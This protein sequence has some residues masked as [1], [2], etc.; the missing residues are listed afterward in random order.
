M[1][2]E[3][4]YYSNGAKF[5]VLDVSVCSLKSALIGSFSSIFRLLLSNYISFF[6]LYF[7]WPYFLFFVLT[8][9][10]TDY[11]AHTFITIF[12]YHPQVIIYCFF[13]LFCLASLFFLVLARL[14]INH[15]IYILTI[16]IF[17]YFQI[18]IYYFSFL[19]CLALFFSSCFS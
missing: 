7:I 10:T 11:T 16:T 18:I 5:I 4:T 12:F 15:S 8:R 9:S 6:L 17:Y 3:M 19:F 14:T 1:R 13:L 2:I